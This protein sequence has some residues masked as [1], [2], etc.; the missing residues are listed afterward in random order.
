[1]DS[2]GRTE[3]KKALKVAGII[4]QQPDLKDEELLKHFYSVS[5]TKN[6]STLE[7]ELVQQRQKYQE[8][9]NMKVDGEENL[10]SRKSCRNY[11]DDLVKPY[12]CWWG[13]GDRELNEQTITSIEVDLKE[14]EIQIT[15]LEDKQQDLSIQVKNL[16]KFEKHTNW[17][18]G[19]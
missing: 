8:L 9:Q 13:K 10:E 1:M 2:G 6:L 19:E 7:K 17:I 11:Y 18:K 12:G 3:R 16:E 14:L 15:Q 4:A 5:G